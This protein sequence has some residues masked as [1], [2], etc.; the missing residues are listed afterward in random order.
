MCYNNINK[1]E[2]EGIRSQKLRGNFP[3]SVKEGRKEAFSSRTCPSIPS[4]SI[5][6]WHPGNFEFS[7]S[8]LSSF[9]PSPAD[10]LAL[11]EESKILGR[12]WDVLK[13]VTCLQSSLWASPHRQTQC[14]KTGL[15]MRDWKCEIRTEPRNGQES[16]SP[17]AEQGY[18]IEA[19][20]LLWHGTQ[21]R[22]RRTAFKYL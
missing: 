6:I 15:K 14:S 1:G 13:V 5:L 20:R 21:L 11:R 18:L 16:Y 10:I 22:T 8:S 4:S 7:L 19:R 3:Q 9:P 17:P 2:S 12:R